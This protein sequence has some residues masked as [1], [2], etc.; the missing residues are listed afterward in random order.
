MLPLEQNF[1]CFEREDTAQKDILFII[2][3]Y[4][5]SHYVSTFMISTHIHI[6]KSDDSITTII[7][8]FSC[9][10]FI[11]YESLPNPKRRNFESTS[12]D[13]VRLIH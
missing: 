2:M 8:H 13:R 6:D 7:L 4:H 10:L 3:S 1:L 9:L 11:V 5:V 12:N